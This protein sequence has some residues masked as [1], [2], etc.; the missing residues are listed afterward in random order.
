MTRII[1]Y[2]Y[3][4]KPR[5]KRHIKKWLKKRPELRVKVDVQLAGTIHS[6]SADLKFGDTEIDMHPLLEEAVR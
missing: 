5:K 6:V 3:P 1:S 2:L 4:R